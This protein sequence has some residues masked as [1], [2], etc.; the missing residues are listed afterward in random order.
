MF[1]V[2]QLVECVEG[3]TSS[4]RTVVAGAVYRVTFVS[5]SGRY[6]MV[7]GKSGEWMVGRFMPVDLEADE[8]K[9]EE[10]REVTMK[11]CI[12]ENFGKTE[13]ALLVQKYIGN[14]LPDTFITVITVKN[15]TVE[16][17]AEAKRM[18]AEAK[19]KSK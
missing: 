18:D 15:N 6:V 11:R 2:G 1:K 7:D 3:Y 5:R 17:L 16:I 19:A 13:D 4:H 9:T 10:N 14:D 8:P 12:S